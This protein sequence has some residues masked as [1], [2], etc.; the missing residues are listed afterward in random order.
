MNTFDL[1][2]LSPERVFYRGKCTSLTIPVDDGMMGIMAN[3]TP[4]FCA[5]LDGE[6]SF[7]DSNGEKVVCAV[8]RG[9]AD[10]EKNRLQI[11]CESALRPDEIDEQ[12]EKLAAEKAK[13]EL[14]K[15]QSERDFAIWQMTFQRAVNNLK[16]KNSFNANRQ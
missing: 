6:L 2:I 5:I 4:F 7:T 11:L 14:E 10:M 13:Q 12:A 9:M 16:V 8:T 3:H 1:E 15:K